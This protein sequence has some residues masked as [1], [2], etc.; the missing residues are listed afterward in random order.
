MMDPITALGIAGNIV[1][2]IDFGLKAVSKARE[3]HSS[4]TGALLEHVD[5]KLLTEDIIVVT[6]KLLVANGRR[7]GNGSLDMICERCIEAAKELLGALNR[8]RVHE[9]S[10]WKS[11]RQALKATWG[12]TR[13][14]ELRKRLEE[15]KDEVQFH[16]LVDLRYADCCI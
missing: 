14:E 1:Q 3:I 4:S 6:E 2:F 10:K 13:V 16:V 5:L 9:K 11:V 8:M 12:K 15:W 7:T